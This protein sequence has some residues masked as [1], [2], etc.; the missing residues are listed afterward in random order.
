M[1]I[2]SLKPL[3]SEEYFNNAVDLAVFCIVNNQYIDN[4]YFTPIDLYNMRLTLLN[5]YGSINPILQYKRV[6][7]LLKRCTHNT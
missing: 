3:K 4:S 1:R 5:E 7:Q 2:K 6:K